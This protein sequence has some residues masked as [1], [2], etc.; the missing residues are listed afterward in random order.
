[1]VGLDACPA[2]ARL[3]VEVQKREPVFAINVEGEVVGKL[4]VVAPV[5]PLGLQ[6]FLDVLHR[7]SG[8]SL[9][10]LEH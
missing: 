8:L 2:E 6:S 4:V 5:D 7:H 9:V 3:V 10:P 1:M